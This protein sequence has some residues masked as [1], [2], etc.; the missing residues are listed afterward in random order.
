MTTE[1][2]KAYYGSHEF[3]EKFIYEGR[4]LGAVCKDGFLQVKLWSPLAERVTLHLYRFGEG[5]CIASFPMKREEKGV[6]SCRADGYGHGTYYDFTVCIEKQELQTADPWAKACNCNGTRSMAVDL[7]KTNPPGWEKDVL[8]SEAE[9]QIIYEV[10]VKDFSYDPSSGVPEEYRGKYK[11]FTLSGTTL[12]G[13]GIHPTCLSYL[14][15]LGVTHVQL[16]PVYDYGSVDE[17]GTDREYNWGYDPQNYNV[18]EGS[19]ATDPYHGEVRIRE[20]KELVQSLHRQGIGVIMDVVYNHTHSIDSWFTKTAPHYFYRQ[21]PDGQYSDGSACGNDVASEREMCGRYILE[22][23]LY[24]AEEYHMDGFRFD[25]MGLLDVEL[26]NR[27]RK[28][29]DGRYGK[30]KILLYGEPWSATDTAM[31]NGAIPCMKES[32]SMLDENVGIFCDNTRDSIKG[33]VFYEDEPGFVN[34]GKNLENEILASV[35]AWAGEKKLGVKGPSQIITYISAHDNHTLWD[36]M[37]HTIKP[38]GPFDCRDEKILRAYKMAAALYFTCQGRLFF[39]AGEEFARTKYG[40]GNSY[41]SSPEV[42]QLD[43]NRAYEYEDLL[44]YYKGLIAFRKQ[45]HGLTDKKRTASERICGQQILRAGVVEF[46]V[47]NDSNDPW[48]TL[49]VCYNSTDRACP[50]KLPEGEW[51]LLLDEESSW[52]WE[53]PETRQTWEAAPVS[54]TIYGKK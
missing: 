30:G 3:K 42:N 29:L 28:A 41:M 40:D 11:A 46:F 14:K 54:V 15:Q 43:W 10:H 8:I 48:E 31:E 49:A 27:I 5:E 50:M 51:Q 23:V 32:I 38:E 20:L 44:E 6:W 4:D 25:L 45:M 39:Q 24:W 13:D 19:Y 33:H 26:I 16:M 2:Y 53:K 34:G 37:V 9:E 17:A 22:S 18:P 36:K 21:F 7:S 35:T 47:N 12:D 52:K 1:E